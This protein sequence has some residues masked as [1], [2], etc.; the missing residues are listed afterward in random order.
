M[1][2]KYRKGDDV[3]ELQTLLNSNG[4][5]LDVD[6][7]Y[8]PK[9]QAAYNDYSN[10]SSNGYVTL[11]P[12]TTTPDWSKPAD[13][14]GGGNAASNGYSGSYYS[15]RYSSGSPNLPSSSD[16]YNEL[17]KYEGSR[18]AAFQ[19]KYE[20]QIQGLLDKIMNREAFSYDFNADPLYQQMKD[21]YTQQGKLA[22]QDA[23]G[24]AAALSGGYGNSYAQTVGQQ[25]YQN[26]MQGLNDVIPELRDAA[27]QMYT[28]EG[29]RMNTNLN[30]LRG[31]D[32][33][34]YGRYRDT[35]GDWY[36][37][38]DYYN[39]KY[40]NLYDR[41]Y[42]AYMDAMAAAAAQA[43]SGGSSGSRG[44]GSKGNS[45]SKVSS[46]IVDTAV[47]A[48]LNAV[49]PKLTPA[50]ATRA[51]LDEGAKNGASSAKQLGDWLVSKNLISGTPGEAASAVNR[52]YYYSGMPIPGSYDDEKKKKGSSVKGGITNRS[53]SK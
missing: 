42:Q 2:S 32:D 26:Y 52:Y 9:T 13:Q 18:P 29:N 15:S 34:D 53:M 51:M 43:A 40:F 28:D 31:L 25:T 24:N 14:L 39:S 22:M 44:S 7:I 48:G 6:G 5:S 23:M 36:N 11:K 27:Y 49:Y 12:N 41:E 16:A 10:R 17:L 4:Y 47:T 19:S 30:T 37:D 50:E 8:G 21:R 20:D 46:S 38:R 35:V 45:S 1:A 33:T 3:K